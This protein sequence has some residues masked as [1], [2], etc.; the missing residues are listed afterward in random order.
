MQEKHATLKNLF[1]A[2][3]FTA[4]T[5]EIY[6]YPFGTGFRFTAG[7]ITLSFLVLYLDSIS[8]MIL[9]PYCGLNVVLFRALLSALIHE[10]PLREAFLFHYPSFFFY[11]TFAVLISATHIR[12]RIKD[13]ITFVTWMALVDL[14]SNFVELSVRGELDI[15]SFQDRYPLALTVGFI[16]STITFGMYWL[17][18]RS[19]ILIMKEEHQKRYAELLSLLAELK[20]ELFYIK[21][22]TGNLEWAM[23]ESYDIYQALDQDLQ[24]SDLGQL[25][26]KALN[27]AKDI[28]E[29]KKDYMRI[30]AGVTE[31]LPEE[32]SDGMKLSDIVSIIKSNTERW[33]KTRGMDIEFYTY[34]EMDLLV[35]HY[36]S[37]TSVINNLIAN[38]LD[39]QASKVFVEVH[40]RRDWL[41]ISVS[42]DG[43]GISPKDLPYIFE[44]GFST[45]FDLDGTIYTGLGLTHAKNLVEDMGGRISAISTLGEGTRFKI[46][47]PVETGFS[48]IKS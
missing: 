14:F 7:V 48:T 30:V 15:I 39:A 45:K 2:G 38:A 46:V 47:L 1:M 36:F 25:K 5:G 9:V 24:R 21:K 33:M 20:A 4:L 11:L 35:K 10:M 29:I 23:K 19:R 31:L 17:F 44:P 27:L 6:F 3:I 16:R 42:D 13:P 41:E 34:I 22:S 37:I 28:H 12:K 32:N 40:S 43:K 18:E 26:K 8:E